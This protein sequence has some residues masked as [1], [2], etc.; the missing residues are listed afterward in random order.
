MSSRPPTWMIVLLVLQ[1][2]LALAGVLLVGSL[3]SAMAQGPVAF[4]HDDVPLLF[5]LIAVFVLGGAALL[6]WRASRRAS[7][8][9]S[10]AP[11]PVAAALMSWAWG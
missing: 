6:L 9:L 8:I 1:L 4:A 3:A 11:F 2:M 10:L 5:P 7:V